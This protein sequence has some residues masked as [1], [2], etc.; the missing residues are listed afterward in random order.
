MSAISGGSV[1]NSLFQVL[2]KSAAKKKSASSLLA[3]LTGKKKP[4]DTGSAKLAAA[5]T[6]ALAASKAGGGADANVTIEKALA[7]IF[8]NGS[9]V[10]QGTDPTDN[11]SRRTAEDAGD[12]Q[13]PIS[14]DFLQVLQSFGVTPQQFQKDVAAAA[15]EAGVGSILDAQS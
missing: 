5:L 2:N 7:K 14:K 11:T 12:G 3:S 6:A 10:P 9:V 4:D 8:K 13:T 15:K 1:T